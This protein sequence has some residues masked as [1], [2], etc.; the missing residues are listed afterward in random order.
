MYH[1]RIQRQE[2]HGK[3]TF[4]KKYVDVECRCAIINALMV[5]F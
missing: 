5:L 2:N 3:Q 4:F 1:A